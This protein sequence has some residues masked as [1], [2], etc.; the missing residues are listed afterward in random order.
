MSSL[1][2][3]TVINYFFHYKPYWVFFHVIL[4]S[5]CYTICGWFA[6]KTGAFMNLWKAYKYQSEAFCISCHGTHSN[7]AVLTQFT[8]ISNILSCKFVCNSNVTRT[9]EKGGWDERMDM[10][11]KLNINIFVT[12]RIFDSEAFRFLL[13]YCIL[14]SIS[15]VSCLWLLDQNFLGI[16]RVW[17][18]WKWGHKLVGEHHHEYDRLDK[19]R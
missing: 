13:S 19:T 17:K 9:I 7:H 16:G 10:R 15:F 11:K 8:N 2:C 1:L 14:L 12:P 3:G 5:F 4:K 6:S 18:C